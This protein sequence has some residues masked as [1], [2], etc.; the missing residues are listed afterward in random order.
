[1]YPLRGVAQDRFAE[2]LVDENAGLA[3]DTVGQA[4]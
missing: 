4:P 3:W 1:M 2:L